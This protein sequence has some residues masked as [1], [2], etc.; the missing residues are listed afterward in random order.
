METD[1]DRDEARKAFRIALGEPPA[2]GFSPEDIVRRADRGRRT[3]VVAAA[4]AAAVLVV[5]TGSAVLVGRLADG[6]GTTFD[7]PID[8]IGNK[9]IPNYNAYAGK[10]VYTINIPG[11]AAPGRMFVGQRK[12]PFVVNLG[13]TFDLI[14]YKSPAVEFDPGAERLESGPRAA[15]NAFAGAP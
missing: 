9:S 8:N 12:D 6:G 7:K 11:C 3:L 2:L 15:R 14:N 10:H 13:E 5:A 4:A 1:I